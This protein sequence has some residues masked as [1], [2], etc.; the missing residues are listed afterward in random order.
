MQRQSNHVSIVFILIVA[1]LGATPAWAQESRWKELDAQVDQLQKQGTDKE[2]LPVTEEALRV[3]EA[4]FG[5][6]HPNTATA[7]SKR[8]T[9]YKTLG[10]YAEAEPL[11]KRSLAIRE[12]ALGPDHPNMAGILVV[13][14]TLFRI[15]RTPCVQ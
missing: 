6:E 11:F 7:L 5:A 10:E 15:N 1:L 14:P 12:K 8:G 4:T 3:A 13:L 2:A 9:T